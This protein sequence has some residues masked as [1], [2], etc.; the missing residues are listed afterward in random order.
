MIEELNK[1]L[2][3]IEF[4]N[5]NAKKEIVSKKRRKNK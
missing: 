1:T 4:F 5:Q 3:L 2:K